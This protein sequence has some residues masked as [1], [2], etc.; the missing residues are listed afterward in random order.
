MEK[1]MDVMEWRR[2]VGAPEL[3]ELVAA[4]AADDK[5]RNES[6]GGAVEAKK[7]SALPP[8]KMKLAGGMARSLNAASMYWHGCTKH[9]HPIL[10][11]RTQ[12]KPWYPNV[13]DEINALIVMADAGIVHGMPMRVTDFVVISH[14]HQPPP[15]NPR[16]AYQMLQGLVKGYPDR[17]NCLISAPVSSIVEFCMN[18]LLPL[19]PGRLPHKFIFLSTGHCQEK[20]AGLLLN[21]YDDVPTFFGGPNT[22]HD[23]FYPDESNYPPA[24]ESSLLKFDFLG[25]V[26]RMKQQ[27]K[28]YDLSHR[29]ITFKE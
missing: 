4:V 1:L 27:R 19:M 2:K 3:Q 8:E 24:T 23:K 17:L 6:N 15:P 20:L 28:E 29:H 21:G 9:G 26:E 18:L 22:D 14:S 7:E 11:I 10:W 5:S 13:Q 12:R 16:F 25:M